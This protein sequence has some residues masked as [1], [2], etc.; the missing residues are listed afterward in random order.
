MDDVE[1]EGRRDTKWNGMAWN[2]REVKGV[3]G[4]MMEALDVG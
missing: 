4:G 1:M 2:E 3:L